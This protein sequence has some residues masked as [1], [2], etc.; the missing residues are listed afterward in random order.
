MKPLACRVYPMYYPLFTKA[1]SPPLVLH[2]LCFTFF[3]N[4][5]L[6][7][8]N[9]DLSVSRF[10]FLLGASCGGGN[11]KADEDRYQSVG[12][13]SRHAYSILDVQDVQGNRWEDLLTY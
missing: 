12:L 6:I 5:F 9:R 13:Q 2:A 1:E 7:I 4:I 8:Q 10:R 3:M 11:M